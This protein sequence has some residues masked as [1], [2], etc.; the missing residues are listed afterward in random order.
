MREVEN[1]MTEYISRNALRR[2]F[3]RIGIYFS[4][5]APAPGSKTRTLSDVI[6]EIVRGIPGADVAPVEH[7]KPVAKMRPVTLTNYFEAIGYV[8]ENGEP[9]YRKKVTYADIPYDH[10]PVC[11]ATLCSRW[12]NYCG[13]CGAKMDGDAHAPD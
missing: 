10:C 8:T 12:H 3:A 11:G 9:L 13:K 6:G 7:G 5:E 1:G 2:A 4:E